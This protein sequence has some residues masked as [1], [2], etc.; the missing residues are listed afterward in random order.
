MKKLCDLHTH[1]IFSDGTFTPEEI[2]DEAVKIGLSA[3]ALCDH[4]TVD[5][6]PRFLAAA[7]NKNIEA[8]SGAEFSVD[9]N[10][11]ELHLLAL[12]IPTKYLSQISELMFESHK[13]KEQNNI[14]LINTLC[15]NGYI[16]DYDEIKSSTPMGKVN[17]AHIGAALTKKGYTKSINEAFSTLLSTNAGFYK[18]PD[19]PTVWEIIDFILS[20]GAVPVLAHPL[21]NLSP[22]ELENFL[23]LAK[24]RG[25]VGIECKYCLYDAKAEKL[26]LNMADKFGLKYSG[27]SD[28]HGSIKPDIDLGVGKGNLQVP[29]EWYLNLKIK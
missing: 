23:P 21:L 11:K 24:Q 29:Y 10:E 3:V 25:L 20:I 1:S 19:R 16:L 4:N 17:R 6:I 28:F 22:E 8:I 12:F 7:K 14:D 9:Y 15:Q 27:G 5:G 18:A 13:H 26:S 2:I